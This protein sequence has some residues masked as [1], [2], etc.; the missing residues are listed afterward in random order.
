M[1]RPLTFS[2]G[3]PTYNQAEYLEETI[4]SLL[5]QT[6]PPDEIVISDHYST[7]N[8]PEII[9]K[10]SKYVRG[11][12]PP[13]NVNLAGQY[14]FTLQSQTSDWITIFCSDDIALPNYGEVLMRGAA[15]D[16]EAVLV[17]A[18]WQTV[19]AKGAVLGTENLLS[20]PRLQHPP[21][22]LL[23]Q[24]HG[25]MVC[26]TS[27]AIRR[28]AFQRSGPILNSIRSLVDWALFVQMAPFGPFIREPEIIAAYRVGHDGNKFR[29]RLAMWLN[30]EQ[31]MFEEVFPLACQRAGINDTSW[32]HAASANNF[33]RYLSTACK[34]IPAAERAEAVSLFEPWA[35]RI[36]R[37]KDLG[38]FAAGGTVSRPTSL[39]QRAR[40]L[41]R[42][43]FH[44]LY[45]MLHKS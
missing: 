42:P 2:V 38:I 20:M 1:A 18:S 34:E 6:R 27:F 32:I 13:P 37:Q 29:Q 3:I 7:D 8:T 33:M 36:N 17:R 5:N 15:R 39:S 12:K 43:Y 4:L 22:T 30:D 28:D 40:K 26:G 35:A 14:S 11:V 10:Y 16:P 45:A 21:Q 24:R 9:A 23:S 19:D 31:R 41:A 25:P 44:R